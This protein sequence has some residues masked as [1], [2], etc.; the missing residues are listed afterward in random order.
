MSRLAAE[1]EAKAA[2]PAQQLRH[3]YVP[4]KGRWDEI[5]LWQL[6]YKQVARVTV[7]CFSLATREVLAELAAPQSLE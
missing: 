6:G 3:K 2:A 1:S 7:M 5:K 4:R